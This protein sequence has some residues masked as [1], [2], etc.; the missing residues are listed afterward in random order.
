MNVLLLLAVVV[1]ALLAFEGLASALL[2]FRDRPTVLWAVG[3]KRS[4]HDPDIGWVN[5][6]NANIPDLYGKGGYV[7]INSQGFRN[8]EEIA[9]RSAAGRIRVICTGD[10]F[11]FGEGVSN[12]DVWCQLL[13]AHDPR[14][15]IVNMG[16]TGYGIDQ[17]YLWYKRDGLPLEHHVHLLSFITDDFFRM[18]TVFF[19]GYAKPLLDVVDGRLVV[20]NLPVPRKSYYATWLARHLRNF[21]GLRSAEL[22]G[23]AITKAKSMLF[24]DKAQ[25][26]EEKNARTR[27]VLRKIFDDLKRIQIERGIQPVLVHLPTLWELS[28]H[29]ADAREWMAFL[30]P[31]LAEV[32]IPIL[33]I[34][35]DFR[36]LPIG[37]L[38]TMFYPEGRIGPN[39]F[40]VY[41]NAVLSQAISR[42][43]QSVIPAAALVDDHH[44]AQEV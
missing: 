34:M 7:R 29:D 2:A 30:K 24:S 15:E 40:N 44:H 6:P 28:G 12:D 37:D 18:Q 41:G 20:T 36:K 33:D 11:T 3:R 13:A 4:Q 32:G 35:D 16:Q 39:H 26:Q 31:E 38:V 21:N 43:L 23:R 14:L 1:L 10:S 8:N 27:V 19:A 25:S 22:V 9:Q 42:R 17:A 5:R